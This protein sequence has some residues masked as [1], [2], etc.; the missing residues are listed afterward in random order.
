MTNEKVELFE[1]TIKVVTGPCPYCHKT[2]LVELTRTE[3]KALAENEVSIQEAL[4]N[5]DAGFRELFITGTHPEH[6]DATTKG[7]DDN[8]ASS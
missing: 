4:P 1:P 3:F 8:E 2:T 5:R 7:E 6:W